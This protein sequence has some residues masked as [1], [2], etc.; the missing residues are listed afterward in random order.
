MATFGAFV[1]GSGEKARVCVISSDAPLGAASRGARHV[2]TA[3]LSAFR[4]QWR[5]ANSMECNEL[6]LHLLT[7]LR[8]DH[9]LSCLNQQIQL[10]TDKLAVRMCKVYH[11]GEWDYDEVN[12]PG[13]LPLVDQFQ[14]DRLSEILG[15]LGQ[16]KSL[17]I[18]AAQFYHKYPGSY[19]HLQRAGKYP[20]VPLLSK[21]LLLEVLEVTSVRLDMDGLLEFLRGKGGPKLKRII[22][23]NLEHSE[24]DELAKR[25]FQRTWT[26]QF[27]EFVWSHEACVNLELASLTTHYPA[28]PSCSPYCPPLVTKF[29]ERLVDMS[30]HF[31]ELRKVTT[32]L[33]EAWHHVSNMSMDYGFSEPAREKI[34]CSLAFKLLSNRICEVCAVVRVPEAMEK[35]HSFDQLPQDGNCN[36]PAKKKRKKE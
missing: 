14:T 1:E 16:L 3:S 33:G 17:R 10:D 15:R 5:Q 28:V 11:H 6:H 29:Q 34:R 36:D 13:H 18:D 21:Y 32:P 2:R 20:L 25:R 4:E 12:D 7:P 35:L 23:G 8:Q 27:I 30:Y 26:A 24:T 19:N 31:P 9:F 22:L